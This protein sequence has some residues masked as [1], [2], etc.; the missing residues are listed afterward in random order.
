MSRVAQLDCLY[1]LQSQRSKMCPCCIN[2]NRTAAHE[3]L[4]HVSAQHSETRS[5]ATDLHAM[6]T[7]LRIV[8]SDH[9]AKEDT[10]DGS[11]RAQAKLLG[12]PRADLSTSGQLHEFPQRRIYADLV[13]DMPF[14]THCD[15]WRCKLSSREPTSQ[16]TSL[17][18]PRV[19]LRFA[20]GKVSTYTQ[21]SG[22]RSDSL[23][24]CWLAHWQK[25]SASPSPAE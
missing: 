25:N 5:K 24:G 11:A 8:A 20:P 1:T 6:H 16:E 12:H 10:L 9:M 19:Q 21:Q 17:W 2:Y 7:L 13:A 18:G 4:G 22:L 14:K 3:Q 23:Q 15:T